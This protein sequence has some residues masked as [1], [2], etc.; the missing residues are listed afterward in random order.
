MDTEWLLSS[1][2]RPS[3]LQAEKPQLSQPVLIGDGLQPSDHPRG[4]PLDL[5]QQLIVLL[6]GA[7][8]LD[9]I[10]RLG[11]HESRVEGHTLTAL[12]E[13]FVN[14]QPQILLLGAA[15]KPHSPPNLYLCLRLPWPRCRT[16]HLALLNFIRLAW[17]HL[18]SLTRFFWIAFL[19]L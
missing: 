13:T 1:L 10:F 4:P 11:S 7:P 18:S 12:V 6:L 15:L 5:L 9:A 8:A 3:L 2:L 19:S 14:Q 17:A 16:L